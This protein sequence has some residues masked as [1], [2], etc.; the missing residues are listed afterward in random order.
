MSTISL[1]YPD[2]NRARRI[3]AA[4]KILVLSGLVLAAVTMLIVLVSASG[5]E[6]AGQAAIS[7]TA[8]GPAA[9]P[10]PVPSSMEIQAGPT[11][12]LAL[13]QQGTSEPVIVPVAVPAPPA[14]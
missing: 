2:V 1:S 14:S 6:P 11:E 5:A 10:V 12:T 9:V 4:G 7:Q 8:I 13:S 3:P